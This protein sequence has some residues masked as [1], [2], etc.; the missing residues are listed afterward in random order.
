MLTIS[1][2]RGLTVQRDLL[3]FPQHTPLISTLT[4][5]ILEVLILLYSHPPPAPRSTVVPPR[6][7]A[8]WYAHTNDNN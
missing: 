4:P 1:F 7:V 6:L 2:F 8:M 3:A 5:A